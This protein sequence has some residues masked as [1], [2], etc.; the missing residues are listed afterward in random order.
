MSRPI[1]APDLENF[2]YARV[3]APEDLAAAAAAAKRFSRY[4]RGLSIFDFFDSIDPTATLTP[5]F[6]A[7]QYRALLGILLGFEP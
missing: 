2:E 7:T 5:K 4:F 6:A 3:L 1:R